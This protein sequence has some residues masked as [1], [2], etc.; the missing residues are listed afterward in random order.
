MKSSRRDFLLTAVTAPWAINLDSGRRGSME[1][2]AAVAPAGQMQFENPQLLRYDARCFTFNGVDTLVMSGAFHYPRCPKELW[3]DRLLKFKMA[4]FNT[5]ETYVFWNYHEPQEGKADLAEFEEFVKLVHEMGLMMIV[6]PGPYVC[7]EWERGGFPSWIAAKRFPLRTADPQSLRT[8]QHWF[9]AVLP[10]IMKYQLMLGGPIIMVQVEN[11]YDYGPKIPDADKRAYVDALAQMVWNAGI[12]APVITCWTAQARENNYPDM[13]KIMDTC[14][15][16]PRWKIV[17]ELTPALEKLRREEPA[18]PLMVTELQGGW[19]S[20]FGGTLS[21]KQDGIDAVQINMLTQTALE[22]GVTSF[23]YYMGHGGTN[24]D[25]AAKNLTTTYDY[26]APIREPGGLGEKYYTVRG[27]G[28]SLRAFGSVLTR[29][30]ALPNIQSSNESVSVTERS[31]G[32]SGV[33]FVRE[34]ANAPQRFKMT[35]T[36]PH[37]PSKRFIF[38][39]RQGELELAPREMKMLPVQIP[40]SGGRLCYTTGELLTHGVNLDREFMILYDL[41]GRV[42]EMGLATQNEPTTAGDTLYRYWDPDYE[43][44]V[45]GVKVGSAEKILMHNDSI[46]IFVMPRE[47]A[48]RT[49]LWEFPP[50]IIPDSE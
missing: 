26:A 40:M 44:S 36:D 32:P 8:S 1:A 16:Y 23:S 38:A 9:S 19:F 39:P 13:A 25:W 27:I 12:T 30:V 6:R 28:Q 20:E 18:S 22:L 37:S 24:F 17:S 34:N 42:L 46:Q 45:L 50:N 21:E 4:G 47:K 31:N 14:N 11:E 48:L 15:F 43:T 29:A 3:R 33:L 2:L 5:I 41:P 35:F 7:A 10:V 49:F